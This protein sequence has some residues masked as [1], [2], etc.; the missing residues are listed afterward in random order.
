MPGIGGRLPVVSRSAW[1]ETVIAAW[2][3]VWLEATY[4]AVSNIAS[5]TA[6]IV[7]SFSRARARIKP[8]TAEAR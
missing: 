6:S 3:F 5:S 1:V 4:G 2:F 8:F 7:A